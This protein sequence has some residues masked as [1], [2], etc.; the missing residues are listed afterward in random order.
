MSKE[1]DFKFAWKKAKRT[2]NTAKPYWSKRKLKEISTIETAL[3][4]YS[5]GFATSFDGDKGCTIV[6]GKCKVC[7][8]Y[9]EQ[10]R[11]DGHRLASMYCKKHRG[12]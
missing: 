5:Y 10:Y 11:K 1:N 2:K 8:S 6:I 12:S 3:E 9:F 4:D 7:K